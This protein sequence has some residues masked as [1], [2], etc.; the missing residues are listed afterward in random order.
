MYLPHNVG[1]HREI[2]FSVPSE[3]IQKGEPQNVTLSSPDKM[4]GL[5]GFFAYCPHCVQISFRLLRPIQAVISRRIL[6][7]EE[8]RTPEVLLLAELNIHHRFK[9][10]AVYTC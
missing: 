1:L 8:K 5:Y 9:I 3:N 7:G 4:S 6:G 10:E 2:P